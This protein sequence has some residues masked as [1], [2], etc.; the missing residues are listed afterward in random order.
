MLK[1]GYALEPSTVN[2]QN[3]AIRNNCWKKI[4]IQWC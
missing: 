1:N 4:S 3:S 2:C